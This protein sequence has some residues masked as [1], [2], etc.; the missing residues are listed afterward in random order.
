MGT[1][2]FR[3]LSVFTFVA[4]FAT[5]VAFPFGFIFIFAIG[6]VTIFMDDGLA[7][8]AFEVLEILAGPVVASADTADVGRVF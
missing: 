2:V 1:L 8:L 7:M 3:W 5:G 6:E 4:S